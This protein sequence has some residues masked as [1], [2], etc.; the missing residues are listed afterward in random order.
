MGA[1][2]PLSPV[3]MKVHLVRHA[4]AGHRSAWSGGDDTERPLTRKGWSQAAG[5]AEALAGQ[6]ITR[7]VS[8][9]YVRCIQTLEPLA[10]ELGIPVRTDRRLEEG[11]GGDAALDLAAELAADG[12]GD[13][14]LCSH[15]DIIPELLH[16]VRCDG[17]RFKEPLVWPKGSTWVLTGDGRRWA[18]ARYVPPPG[19]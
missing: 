1:A 8:S 7:L 12:E 10:G 3:R 2:P 15:G 6:G 18:K 5:I 11:A 16:L 19:T 13:A 17:T 14:V 9:P 4:A